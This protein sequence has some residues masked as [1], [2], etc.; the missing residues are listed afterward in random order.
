[1]TDS[2]HQA[3]MIE[4]EL[5]VAN[6]EAGGRIVYRNR[7]WTQ[8]L[9][10]QEDLWSRLVT[11]DEEVAQQNFNEAAGGSLVTNALF[12][13]SRTEIEQPVPLL[14]HFIPAAP[15]GSSPLSCPRMVTITGEILAEPSSWTENQTERHRMETLGRMTMGIAHDFNNLLSGILGHVA[16]MNATTP[17]D[18][19]EHLQTIE[20]AA[21]DG[22]AL[23]KKIQRYI[24]QEQQ[25]SFEVLDLSSLIQDCIILTRPYWYN[26]PRRQ[27][28]AID[29]EYDSSPLP[30][31]MGSAAELRDVFVNLIL[32]AV[33]AMPDGGTI[34]I[35]TSAVE[36]GI[37]IKFSD[38]GTGM[39][40]EVS[41]RIFEP[42]F[43][44]KGQTGS[45]MGLSVASGVIRE[46]EGNIEVSSALGKGSVFTI[47]LPL[48]GKIKV[49]LR[50]TEQSR[51]IDPARVLVVDDEEMVLKV[52]RQLLSLRGHHV[53]CASSGAEALKMLAGETYDLV[54]SDQGMPD[55]GGRELASI[56]KAEY[57]S[58]P[59]ALLT[60]DTDLQFD[61]DHVAAV[62]TKP[63]KADDLEDL[64]VR[65]T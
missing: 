37:Q 10:D 27:G 22:A 32:N 8:I 63:F 25:D 26:E 44:T 61:P 13:A 2:L 24:R 15:S 11:G 1:M 38:T 39:S 7:A 65:L 47:S 33:Q 62:V 59:V 45:G 57:P 54:I 51:P 23:V 29:L 35:S 6:C 41:E 42:L 60:G 49:T 4:P 17:A 12:M 34:A 48:S 55:M 14:L 36:R 50:K 53:G 16:I 18:V 21:N 3:G 20:Q 5:L 64:I 9:G 40:P 58:I 43:T 31:M 19:D 46:H 30:P 28:I 52:V 56:I